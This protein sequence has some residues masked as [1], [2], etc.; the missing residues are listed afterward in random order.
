MLPMKHEERKLSPLGIVAAVALGTVVV[1]ALLN[2]FFI[3]L[4]II[5]IFV[6]IGVIDFL[7]RKHRGD[8]NNNENNQE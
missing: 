5:G 2:L 7:I 1:L 4:I 6:I 8:F 3:I